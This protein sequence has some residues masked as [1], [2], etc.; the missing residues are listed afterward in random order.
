[1]SDSDADFD[2]ARRA[3]DLGLL[4]REQVE[5]AIQS[6]DRS[7]GTRLLAH[8][9]LTPA[10]IK[11]LES[12]RP[13][14]AEAAAAMQDPTKRV[15]RFWRVRKLGGGG[16]GMVF[17]AWEPDLA[18]WV[19]L[20]FLRSLADE[21]ALA[22]FRREA[23]LAAALDHPNIAKIYEIGEHEGAPY[24]AMEFV[25]GTTLSAAKLSAAERVTATTTVAEAVAFAHSR[26]IIHRDLK[27]SNVMVDRQGHVFVLD[28]GLAKEIAVDAPSLTGTNAVLGTPNYMAPEQAR[29]QATAQSDVYSIGAILYELS[30]G[31]PPFVG[32]TS[33]DVLVQVLSVEPIWPRRLSPGI[34]SDLEAIILRALEKDPRRRYPGVPALLEDLRAFQ[35]Q[36]PLRHAR[37]PTWGYVLAKRIRKQPLLW[38]FG[39]MAIAAILGGGT[40]GSISLA[41]RVQADRRAK[42]QA[43]ARSQAEARARQEAESRAGAEEEGRRRVEA[44]QEQLVRALAHLQ[45]TRARQAAE[46]GDFTAAAALYAEANRLAPST[47]A[48]VNTE[49]FLSRHPRLSAVRAHSGA[50]VGLTWDRGG[51]LAVAALGSSGLE[52]AEVPAALS[53]NGEFLATAKTVAKEDK[54]EYLLRLRRRNDGEIVSRERI[55]VSPNPV[56]AFAPDGRILYVHEKSGEI[57]ARRVP[58]LEDLTLVARTA[59]GQVMM[60]MCVSSDGTRMYLFAAGLYEIAE[61]R[62]RLLY[63]GP[64]SMALFHRLRTVPETTL[65]MVAA[66]KAAALFDWRS[67]RMA[68]TGAAHDDYVDAW[69]VAP[70]RSVW[71]TGSRDGTV[72]LWTFPECKPAGPAMRVAGGVLSLLFA[73]DG[74]ALV[75][76]SYDGKLYRWE[77]PESPWREFEAPVPMRNFH[78][79]PNGNRWVVEGHDRTVRIVDSGTGREVGTPVPMPEGFPSLLFSQ[80]SARLAIVAA[81][82]LKVVELESGRFL[83]ELTFSGTL[84]WPAFLPDG[85]VLVTEKTGSAIWTPGGK[86]DRLPEGAYALVP[87]TAQL[88]EAV[89]N[90]LR[91][92]DLAANRVLSEREI[93]GKVVRLFPAGAGNRGLCHFEGGRILV[94]GVATLAGEG[95][96]IRLDPA[97]ESVWITEDGSVVRGLSGDVEVLWS[98]RLGRA[99]KPPPLPKGARIWEGARYDSRFV[100]AAV[101]EG[102]S[103]RF[104]NLE[105]GEPYGEAF[106]WESGVGIARFSPDGRSFIVTTQN[107]IRLLDAE[108]GRPRWAPVTLPAYPDDVGFD[109][110]GRILMIGCR[111]EGIYFLDVESGGPVGMPLA[112]STRGMGMSTHG[113]LDLRTGRIVTW[114]E[115]RIVTP[116]T[117]RVWDARFLLATSDP[118]TLR[119]RTGR[120]TGACVNEVGAVEA[121]PVSEWEKLSR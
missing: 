77:L 121:L 27:P 104:W 118:N 75:A 7:Q 3:V 36:E 115:S 82:D 102:K 70:D 43:E 15:G 41:G 109:P 74:R 10:Q 13:V 76:G 21:Q 33:S 51:E 108:T 97:P 52:E 26:G 57:R 25:D 116:N 69:D 81:K 107:S 2:L 78:V 11:T 117:I 64:D 67:Q 14:P 48:T 94:F 65:L 66:G 4:R 88:L 37:R 50:I 110:S 55:E 6:Y 59:P 114:H 89:G 30:T 98:L 16:M 93:S 53:P 18:R 62:T 22:F 12:S 73:P 44:K 23:Q 42:Q 38:T 54:R 39:A 99:L 105:K 86:I 1:M 46:A 101:H 34:A 87:G 90:R 79:S 100:R 9:P 85:R 72:R 45:S 20:K 95:S 111:G 29:G 17:L 92:R 32:D 40:F 58:G 24:I 60:S 96:E 19:A 49:F 112:H 35:A 113:Y 61:G 83:G 28:F 71:A 91:L 84:G 47:L 31:R 68:F 5:A 103:G 119:T 106:P 120:I 8:L 56:V 63:G 80:D